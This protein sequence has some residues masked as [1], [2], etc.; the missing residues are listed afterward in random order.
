MFTKGQWITLGV[1]AAAVLSVVVG[2][3]PSP[4]PVPATAAP[5]PTP[6]A[7]PR[8]T[9]APSATPAPT[10]TVPKALLGTYK[11]AITAKDA[12]GQ[13]YG[14]DVVGDWEFQFMEDGHYLV[15]YKGS[16]VVYSEFT[17]TQDTIVFG[18]ESGVYGGAYS[19]TYLGYASGTYKWS[20]DGKSL[21]LTKVDDGC[22]GRVLILTAHPLIKVQ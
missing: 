22:A 6:T 1:I 17:A 20:T 13:N 10:V 11:T 9:L 15:K 12:G 5:Q 4:T 3:A 7:P 2:C 8:P 19:C 21:T 18:K 16:G 14:V